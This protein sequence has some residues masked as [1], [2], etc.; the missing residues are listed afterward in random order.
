MPVELPCLLSQQPIKIHAR[1][2]NYGPPT[3]LRADPNTTH[4]HI[5]PRPS[6]VL[7]FRASSNSN[8]INNLAQTRNLSSQPMPNGLQFV[9]ICHTFNWPEM[10][11]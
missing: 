8:L 10:V 3:L 2:S 6:L 7:E 11:V 1:Y 4:F 9:N 5:Q